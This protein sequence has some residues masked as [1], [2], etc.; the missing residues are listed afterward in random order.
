MDRTFLGVNLK[1]FAEISSLNV[2]H[3][4]V[5]KFTEELDHFSGFKVDSR[6]RSVPCLIPFHLGY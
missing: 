1:I 4:F 2:R 5:L 6:G 3:R